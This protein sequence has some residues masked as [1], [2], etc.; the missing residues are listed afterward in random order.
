MKI[1]GENT[2]KKDIGLNSNDNNLKIESENVTLDLRISGK[3]NVLSYSDGN[4][5]GLNVKNGSVRSVEKDNRAMAEI[6]M[7]NDD[8]TKRQSFS[9]SRQMLNGIDKNTSLVFTFFVEKL[10]TDAQN[11]RFEIFMKGSKNPVLVSYEIFN[12]KEGYNTIKLD[13]MYYLNWKQLG[14]LK[15]LYF[16]MGDI[17]G[18]HRRIYLLDISTYV[19]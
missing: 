8:K 13:K 15:E 19:D 2:L 3:A 12:L 4:T 16:E 11:I 9:F 6:S 7:E 17:D 18:A 10:P 5:T 1:N 14:T